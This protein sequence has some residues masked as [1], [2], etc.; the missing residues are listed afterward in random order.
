MT[1]CLVLISE[2]ARMEEPGLDFSL[3]D[4]RDLMPAV[5]LCAISILLSVL[6]L[7]VLAKYATSKRDNV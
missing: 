3:L 6:W 7:L 5:I 1:R 4:A 2:G